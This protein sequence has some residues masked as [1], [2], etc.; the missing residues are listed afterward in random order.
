MLNVP[1]TQ[2]KLCEL[3]GSAGIPS[4]GSSSWQCPALSTV[5][6]T[7]YFVSKGSAGK[8]LNPSIPHCH[9][10]SVCPI[11][12]QGQGHTTL[13]LPAPQTQL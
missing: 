11:T 8:A 2:T 3:Q 5:P 6:T 12:I 13:Q 7:K 9:R 1:G 4:Q 10:N